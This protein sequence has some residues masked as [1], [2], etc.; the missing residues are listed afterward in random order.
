MT[1]G[2]ILRVNAEK[3]PD[4]I[5]VKDEKRELTFKEFNDRACRLANAL[6][7]LGLRRGDRVATLLYNNV[8]YM[9]I[10]AACAK[11]GLICATIN[12]RFIGE[13]VK[14]II[15]DSGSRLLFVGSDFINLSDEVKPEPDLP[16][17]QY[18]V[19]VDGNTCAGYLCYD[20][21]IEQASDRPPGL[22]VDPKDPWLLLYTSG[23]TGKPKGVVRTHESYIAF[24]LINEVEYGFNHD[25][26]GLIVMPMF[27][28]NSTFYSFVFTYIGA[29]VYIHR[30]HLFDPEEILKVISNEGI[31]FTSL[32]PTHYTMM[33]N[34]PE[35]VKAK[36]DLSSVRNLLCSSAPV[37]KETKL[38][39]M[40]MFPHVRL[41]EAY[42]STEAGLVTTLRPE[43]QMTKLGSIGR[44]C[45]GSDSILLLDRKGRE[46][47]VG[48]V[49]EIWSRS[50]MMFDHY[51]GMPDKT[52]QCL[53]LDGYFSA[54]DMATKD[55]DGYFS[56]VDRKDNMIITGGEHVYPN[57]VE[58]ILCSHPKVLD[59]AIV[60]LPDEKWGEAVHAAIILRNGAVGEP[61]EIIDFC[62]GKMAGYKKPKGVTF[63]KADEMPRT[64]TG[65]VRHPILR[66]DLMERLGV[67]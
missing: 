63:I 8:E 13:E 2:D 62:K 23:T 1:L 53:R 5:A 38:G 26:I 3:F 52:R 25:D 34:L 37:R 22:R 17:I 11:A 12:F 58:A 24:F 15:E 66:R 47:E 30:A 16:H 55:E 40:E 14:Y 36:Y 7:T 29:T 42:G 57:E 10:Y 28:V 50:P 49:G 20:D 35:E 64:A 6:R 9:E 54:G 61:K 33:L 43:D 56:I 44:E 41:F 39:I 60:G 32:V 51:W 59:C 31:T 46:C 48:E 19:Q 4:K 18:I 27:H 67:E 65:K 45:Y 21:L